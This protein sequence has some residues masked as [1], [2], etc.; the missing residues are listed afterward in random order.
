M[1][2]IRTTKKVVNHQIL[3]D[4]PE[5]FNEQEVE[6]IIVPHFSHNGESS[7]SELLLSGPVWSKKDVQEFEH[8]VQKGYENWT[9]NG[10]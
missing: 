7:L 6:V 8:N 10:F 5:L 9:I 2:A 3:I 4:V 1:E